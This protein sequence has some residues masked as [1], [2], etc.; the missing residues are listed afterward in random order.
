MLENALIA[1]VVAL[2]CGA[3]AGWLVSWTV[4]LRLH[5]LELELAELLEDLVSEKRKRAAQASVAARAARA[6]EFDQQVIRAHTQQQPRSEEE[7]P[8]WSSIVK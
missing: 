6:S 8:W 4:Q 1:A 2:C 3:G 7:E 5:R